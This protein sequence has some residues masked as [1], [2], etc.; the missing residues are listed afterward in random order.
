[1]FQASFAIH[2][3]ILVILPGERPNSAKSVR[4]KAE[5]EIYTNVMNIL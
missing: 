1:M 4:K 5:I 3:K 2:S